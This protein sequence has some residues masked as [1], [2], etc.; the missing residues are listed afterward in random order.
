MEIQYSAFKVATPVPNYTRRADDKI[1][2]KNGALNYQ[3]TTNQSAELAREQTVLM[4]CLTAQNFK[5]FRDSL[6]K[7]G[8][9]VRVRKVLRKW[10]DTITA[11]SPPSTN[12]TPTKPR[13]ADSPSMFTPE[14]SG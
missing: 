14:T 2:S 3:R 6:R 1:C 12:P 13:K 4:T 9:L 5:P 11:A 8:A 10:P 7:L